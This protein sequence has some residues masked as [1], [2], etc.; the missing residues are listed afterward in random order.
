MKKPSPKRNKA[1]KMI[2]KI[3]VNYDTVFRKLARLER[4][5]REK[6]CDF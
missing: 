4:K 5:E 3:L 1:K 6:Y 2:A